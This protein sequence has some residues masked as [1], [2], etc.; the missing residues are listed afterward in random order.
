MIQPIQIRPISTKRE[1]QQFIAFA[2]NLYKD[3]PYY[4][5]PL[6]LDE[7]NT[8]DPKANPSLEV[9]DIQMW[10]AYRGQQPVGRIAAFIN[11]IANQHWNVQRVRFGWMDF[12][13]DMEVS[14]ALLDTVAAWGKEHGMKEMNG[15]VGLTDWDHEGLLLQGYEYLAPMASLYNFPYYVQHLEHYGLT[16]EADWIEYQITA[17][18]Q[19]PERVHRMA[20][21]VAQRSHLRID[22]VR[23]GKELSNKYGL[24][25]MDVL[26]AAYH[27]LYNFQPMTPRQKAHYR[28]MYFPLV[29]FDFAAI[30]VNETNEIV[31]VGVG[32]PDIAQALR[33]CQGKL[34]PFGWW[35]LLRAL[36]SKHFEVFNL[37]L[38]A[39]RPDYRDKGVNSLIFDKIIPSFNKYGV[40]LI[41]TTSMLETNHK[42]LAN[43]EEYD[44]I[45]HKR[46]RAYIKDI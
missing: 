19:V 20:Q 18:Q 31:G 45:Q 43:F 29:N 37:L 25:F 1:K 11:R 32:M 42:V 3:C 2:N 5:P 23:S 33:K 21:I 30:V 24:Q 26:D 35:H 14:H 40:K 13:D 4:C 22:D 15:P 46:R 44:K 41:E 39:V 34:F 16:K 38:I 10:M 12:I 7:M 17:P 6:W 28:D 8:F 9:C 36:H 27:Q